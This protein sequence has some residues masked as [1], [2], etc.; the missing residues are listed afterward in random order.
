FLSNKGDLSARIEA[1]YDQRLTQRLIFQP[2]VELDFAFSDDKRTGVG[3]GL[4][5]AEAGVR[6][7]YEFSRRFAPY[8]GLVHER[9]LGETGRLAIASGESRRE[10]RAVLGLRAWF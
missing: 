1:Y 9:R 4:G 3:S 7:R 8:V 2:R 5:S 10:T 6:L